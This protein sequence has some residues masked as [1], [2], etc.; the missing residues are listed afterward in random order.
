MEIL[1]SE[2][3]HASEEWRVNRELVYADIYA[4]CARGLGQQATKALPE[5][6]TPIASA[7]H[8]AIESQLRT[9]LHRQLPGAGAAQERDVERL[10]A[11][12]MQYFL[13]TQA[14]LRVA[15]DVQAH[16]NAI[17]GRPAPT[18][19]FNANDVDIHVVLQGNEARRLPYLVKEL[20]ELLGFRADITRD[21]I[22]ITDPTNSALIGSVGLDNRICQHTVGR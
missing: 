11:C 2:T 20:E 14:V 13:R 12:L 4:Q 19:P 7:G 5:L 6:F 10:L 3:L 9:R 15:C 21:S 17:L 1:K 22:E 18:A 8:P 16:I